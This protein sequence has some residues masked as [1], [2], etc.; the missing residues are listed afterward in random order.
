MFIEEQGWEGQLDELNARVR[1]R[2]DAYRQLILLCS[3]DLYTWLTET[4]RPLE[5]EL[6]KTYVQAVR[7][8]NKPTAEA[9]ATRRSFSRLLRED[10]ILQFRPEVFALRNPI[11][12]D[13]ANNKG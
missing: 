9:V 3:E 1:Q 10:M 13:R 11:E 7:W 4:Y 12:A 6:K 5:Y 8:G 2:D